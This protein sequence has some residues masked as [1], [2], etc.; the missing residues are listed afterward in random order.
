[1]IILVDGNVS[2]GKTTLCLELQKFLKSKGYEVYFHEETFDPELLKKYIENPREYGE[3][4]VLDIC[5]RKSKVLD[6]AKE[7]PGIHLVDRSHLGD[8][9][10][11]TWRRDRGDI[12]E[13]VL[14]KAQ[15]LLTGAVIEPDF[16]FYLDTRPEICL[17][18]CKKRGRDGE[19]LYTID[20]FSE[21]EKYNEQF[22]GFCQRISSLSDAK[23]RLNIFWN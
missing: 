12:S 1:M 11:F 23:K 10:I 18:R 19:T 4:F 6:Y 21:I 20:F 3:Q 22:F 15:I 13:N 14:A 7:K 16:H 8:L 9:A 2:A 5:V 17:E